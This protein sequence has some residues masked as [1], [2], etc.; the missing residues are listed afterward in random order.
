MAITGDSRYQDAAREYA[1]AHTYDDL[2]RAEYTDKSAVKL[3][4][5]T[6]EALYLLST[7]FGAQ[8]PKQ[9]MVKSTDDVQ[10][11]SYTS[12][13]DPTLWWKIANANPTIRNMFD[14][15]MGDMIHLPE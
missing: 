9:Y 7:R 11:L 13:G 6:R 1:I 3:N 4:E 8:P 14:L 12:Q 2:T 5:V 10:T 15:K